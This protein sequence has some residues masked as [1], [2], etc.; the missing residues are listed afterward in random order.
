MSPRTLCFGRTRSTPDA[1]TLAFGRYLGAELPAP[2]VAVDWSKAVK[3][4]PMY[5]NDRYG[6]CTCAAAGHMVEAWTAAAGRQRTPTERAV[7]ELYEQFTP[8]GPE[9]GCSMLDVLR[10]WR[11][12]GLG[13][14]RIDAFALLAPTNVKQAKQSLAIF[15]GC[16]LGLQ[17]PQFLAEAEDLMAV[18]WTLRPYG[19]R[20]DGAPDPYAGHCVNA[21]GY[22]RR[23][24]YVV[25]WGAVK[26]M[27]WGFYGAYCDESYAVLSEDFL[28]E[29]VT[30]A[31]FDLKQLQADLRAISAVGRAA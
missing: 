10:Y 11:K 5:A 2:P 24:V 21:V 26:A 30:P 20:G 18:P 16:Y 29:R 22:D 25:T 15:G 7:L 4:W 1:R 3:R 27:S 19:M 14:D 31:G 6:D 28:K 8:P 17:L 12:S 9:N 13:T 23:N